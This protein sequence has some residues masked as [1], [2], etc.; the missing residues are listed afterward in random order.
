MLLFNPSR[1]IEDVVALLELGNSSPPDPLITLHRV[2]ADY[3]KKKGN[4]AMIMVY[5]LGL[6]EIDPR[7]HNAPD[8]F[9]T[10]KVGD[11]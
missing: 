3:W 1:S 8:E 2:Q 9:G 4:P 6:I 7:N 10:L 11:R 5:H